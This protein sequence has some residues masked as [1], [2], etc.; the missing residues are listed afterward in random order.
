MRRTLLVAVLVALG[1]PNLLGVQSALAPGELRSGT[2]KPGEQQ[3]LVLAL[4]ANECARLELD[5]ALD[6]SVTLSK[7]DG[8]TSLLMANAVDEWAPAPLTIVAAQSGRHSLELRL[9][10]DAQGGSYTLR[11]AERGAVTERDRKQAEGE[12]HLREGMRLFRL[13]ARESRLAAADHYKQAAA[14]FTALDNQPMLAKSFD[15]TGQVYSGL[16]EPRLALEANERALALYRTLGLRGREAEMLNGVG[17]QLVNQGR[18]TDAIERL[19]MSAAIFHEIGEFRLERSPINNL[20]LAYGYMGEVET[21]ITYYRRALKIAEDNADE[22]GE[23]FA[24]MGLGG[25]ADLKGNVQDALSYFT[26]AL[27]RYR[28]L[29][30][31]QL[32]ALALGNIGSLY[33]RFGDAES[34]LNYYTRSQEVRK[35]A[36]NRVN[37]ANLLGNIARAYAMLGQPQKALEFT[38]MELRFWR[39]IGNK[40][41]E[42]AAVAQVGLMQWRLGD[43]EAAAASFESALAL[44]RE[45][46]TRQVEAGALINL[47]R[48]RLRQASFADAQTLAADALAV[49]R[50]GGLRVV[51]TDALV[52]L[53][54]AESASGALDAAREH[55]TAAVDLA[56]SVRSTV[57]GPDLR[58]VIV[59]GKYAVYDALVDALMRL[60]R[61]RPADGFDRQAFGVS[62]RARARSLLDLIAESRSNIREGVDPKLL[63]REQTLRAQL[64]LRRN[65]S[66]DRVQGLL[67]Q[68]RELQNEMRARNP[69]YSALVDPPVAELAT[70]QRELLDRDTALVEYALGEEH[71]YAWIVDSESLTAHELPPR[72]RIEALARRAHT[73]LSRSQAPD[74]RVALQELSDAIVTPIAA[75]IAGKRLAIVTEGALQYIPFAALPGSDGRPLIAAH[76]MVSLPSASTLGALRADATPRATSR[77]VFVVGDPVFDANDPRVRRREAMTA[78]AAGALERSARESGV[79]LDRL[80]FTRR[81]ADTIASLVPKGRAHKL[82]DFDASLE[83]IAGSELSE[84]RVVHFATH[85]LLN[86]THPELSGLVFSLVDPQGRPRNG[87]LPAYE[88]YN[89]RLNA[90]LVVLSACQTALG[91]DIRGEGL[92]GLTR[93]FMYAGTPRVVASLWRVPDS[94]TAALM[95][96]FYRG[97]F[98]ENRRPADALRLAQESVRAERRW[99][100]PYYWAGF[101]LVG[102][103]K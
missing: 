96:R 8:T 9:R 19:K 40:P 24:Y 16:G 56:E 11:F 32:E 85:G 74:L 20:G 14:I 66:D 88:V 22:S 70:V 12:A 86:N 77:S 39:E 28:K 101:T 10:D 43:L 51:E 60:H 55:A 95:A 90:D 79:A 89:L 78:A 69:R 1:A 13:G 75:R 102:E 65:D 83:R 103:W 59:R 81:E 3:T 94:A 80:L 5:T 36:P 84:S 62:E 47:S 100:A 54:R 38:N 73:A 57:V 26:R 48:M 61:Q 6:F 63:L 45:S 42:A 21:S 92:V 87:F 7:P 2:M 98:T 17:L 93:A 37:E 44:G 49:A 15:K 30:N 29:G 76:E 18:Y 53:A 82:L 71:S 91:E 67:I 58:T 41:S 34:A 68:F 25:T 31:H 33:L 4:E 27:E 35:L 97:L 46:K 72:A 64:T 99:S 52:A 50:A 23:A